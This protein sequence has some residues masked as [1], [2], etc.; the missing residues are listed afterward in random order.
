L[1]GGD[2]ETI[3]RCDQ[4]LVIQVSE[5][6]ASIRETSG[7]ARELLQRC[8]GHATVREIAHSVRLPESVSSVE[9]VRMGFGLLAE[10]G[11]I[12]VEDR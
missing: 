7:F 11:Y 6:E 12:R 4:L 5:D 9:E 8:D 1:H 2:P 10:R 3:E